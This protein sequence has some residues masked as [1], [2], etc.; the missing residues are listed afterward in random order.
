MKV[1]KMAVTLITLIMASSLAACGSGSSS[2][3]P[4]PAKDDKTVQSPAS[5]NQDKVEITFARGKDVTGATTQL[6]KDFEAKNPNITV[7]LREMPADS[8]QSHDQYVTMFNA[9]SSDV[10]VFDIDVVWPAEFAQAGYLEPLDNLLKADNINL[11]DYIQGAVDA[12]NFNGKQWAMPR[13]IDTGLL[14]YRKDIVDKPPATWEDLIAAAKADKGKNGTKYG[15]LMQAKQYEGLVCN[16]IEF[17]SA[18]GGKVV[19]DKG[20]IIINS[21]QTIK[22]LEVMKQVVSSDF[23]PTNITTYTELESHTGFI[24]GESAFI[25]NWPYQYALAQDKT[26]SKIVDKIGVAPLPKGDVRSAAALGGWMTAI[27]KN[28]KHK[29]EAWAFLKYATSAEGEKTSALIGGAS[30]T[31]SALYNDAELKSKNPIYADPGF[32]AGISAA[33]SRPVSPVYPK[34]SDIMQTEISKF[35]AGQESAQDAV[36]NMDEKMKAVVK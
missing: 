10:D 32:V 13:F 15:Y 4:T 33:V 27:N 30:P 31:F 8:G 17:I 24:N 19:D 16:A 29:K 21:P 18:Y 14:F 22:G 2:S 36:K 23:V 6:V 35:L 7:K 26:Q 28:S 1:K 34:L 5:S 9:A 11:K 25:R 20:G 3:S 12:A